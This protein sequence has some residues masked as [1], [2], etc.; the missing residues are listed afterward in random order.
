MELKVLVLMLLLIASKYALSENESM[1]GEV[2]NLD[3]NRWQIIIKDDN[4]DTTISTTF[5]SWWYVK[6]SNIDT[7][8]FSMITI[9]GEG[10]TGARFAMPVYSYDS[11]NWIPLHHNEITNMTK[12]SCNRRVC[13]NYQITKKFSKKEVYLARH[14]PYRISDLYKFLKKYQR[15]R[16]LKIDTIGYSPAQ[17]PII[18]LTI[19]NINISDKKKCRILIH[20][21][22]HPS[23]TMSSF[24]IEGLIEALLN[25]KNQQ[26]LDELIFNII[27]IVN[28]DGVAYG[29]SRN[30]LKGQNLEESW[31]KLELDNYFL[32]DKCPDEI[33]II[34]SNYIKY[35]QIDPK[36][37]AAI[38]IHS[39]NP[40]YYQKPYAFIFSNFFNWSKYEE[41]GKSLW[42]KQ[43]KFLKFLNEEYCSPVLGRTNP[44]M[45]STIDK[46]D[47]PES[48]WWVNFK[49]EIM[50]VTLES[51][52]EQICANGPQ[53]SD[54][55]NKLL[56]QALATALYKYFLFLKSINFGSALNIESTSD[57]FQY[58]EQVESE[59]YL[60]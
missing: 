60:K 38:N 32:D 29:L 45:T 59:V 27:P 56:G 6:I 8:D 57:L 40:Q 10:F 49:D 58:W 4:N 42:I 46:K 37:I 47:F 31:F 21:R 19:T 24:V 53:R 14:F 39:F 50:A 15:D 9:K 55:A 3:K 13:Y 48:W 2:I 52:P 28:V 5:R 20:S 11:E 12:S 43:A 51:S 44:K 16:W 23:E 26:I 17:L 25:P 35:T 54:I 18:E 7:C 36:I 34:H 41:K 30:N 1:S 22:T 33:Y